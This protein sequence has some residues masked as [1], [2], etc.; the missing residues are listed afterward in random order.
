MRWWSYECLY[1]LPFSYNKAGNLTRFQVYRVS[2]KV[3]GKWQR[4]LV[5]I[6]ADK[7]ETL[8]DRDSEIIVIDFYLIL[9]GLIPH[10]IWQRLHA[11]RLGPRFY[12]TY[13]NGCVYGYA[14]FCKKFL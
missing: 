3:K 9:K 13:T 7:A 11:S 4:V 10:Q 5:R 1:V 2:V 14:E 6:Y 8:V 12:G